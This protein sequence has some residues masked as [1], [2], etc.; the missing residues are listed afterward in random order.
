MSRKNDGAAGELMDGNAGV[1]EYFD[2]AFT[3]HVDGPAGEITTHTA[4]GRQFRFR[5]ENLPTRPHAVLVP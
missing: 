5:V 4:G 1:V 3:M 2:V